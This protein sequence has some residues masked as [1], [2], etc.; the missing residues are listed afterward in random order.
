MALLLTVLVVLDVTL[1][2]ST[3]R[4]IGTRKAIIQHSTPASYYRGGTSRGVI[5]QAKDLP[6]DAE[7]RRSMFLQVMGA[8]DPYGRQL[9]GMGAGISSLSKICIVDPSDR[10]EADI[11]YT[12]VGVGIEKPVVDMA[13]N[14]GNMSTAIGPYA[15]N[16]RLLRDIDY[17]VDGMV[18][19]RIFNVNTGKIIHNTFPVVKGQAQVQG[20][21]TIDGVSG[22]GARVT[23]D[24]LDPAGSKTGSLLPTGNVIDIID[25][26][27]VSCVDAA[28][29]GVFVRAEEI[30]IDGSMLPN[31]L[32]ELPEKLD[33]LNKLR[34]KAA[35][36]MGMAKDPA[37]APRTVPKIAV[38]SAPQRHQLL[39][40]QFLDHSSIDVVIRFISDEQPHRAIPL[41]GALCTAAA[42]MIKG[43]I[44][45]QKLG[46]SKVDD[47]MITIGHPSGRIQVAANTDENGDI[48]SATVFR[49]ARRIMDGRVYW[50]G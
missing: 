27:E 11:T 33:L 17:D 9:D 39:S 40:G 30:G 12:F 45:Q 44:V 7:T 50:S 22:S 42:A 23:L 36:A 31:N 6:M 46:H 48:K 19:V 24:F 34:A 49:T 29:P 4:N 13:G 3:R 25:G 47:A 20:T 15:F 26:V 32:K 41:T 21:F 38:V 5:F 18:T 14:C 37:E 2:P 43:S 8:P 35:V 10:P 1:V 28:N 16:E